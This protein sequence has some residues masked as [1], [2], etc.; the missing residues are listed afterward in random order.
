M[1]EDLEKKIQI[2]KRVSQD[3]GNLRIFFA[4]TDHSQDGALPSLPPSLSSD[5]VDRMT[6]SQKNFSA[7]KYRPYRAP[8][9]KGAKL[10]RKIIVIV[11]IL[12]VIIFGA[13]YLYGIMTSPVVDSEI[14]NVPAD[15]QPIQEEDLPPVIEP[16]E[17]KEDI[18]ATN[19]PLIVEEESKPDF[20]ILDLDEDGLNG[21][22]EIELG[23]NIN[24]AD[25]D[26][27]GLTD[28]QEVTIYNT[29]P[30][31][32]DSDGDSYSDGNEVENGYNPLGEGKL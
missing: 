24:K 12:A 26:D 30:L 5:Q 10:L 6:S 31:Q 28:W 14:N 8:V 29:D 18:I 32:A 2:L 3:Q 22:E 13:Y 4:E 21:E 16:E 1:F 11:I 15:T 17:K 23:T 7:E 25:T 9:P 20:L 27:D 19:T